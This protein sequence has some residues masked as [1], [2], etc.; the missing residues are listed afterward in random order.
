MATRT[1]ATSQNVKRTDLRIQLFKGKAK[2]AN[3]HGVFKDL[4]ELFARS[5]LCFTTEELHAQEIAFVTALVCHCC[6]M[7]SKH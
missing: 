6:P 4:D 3:G 1:G 5:V 7:L 2:K